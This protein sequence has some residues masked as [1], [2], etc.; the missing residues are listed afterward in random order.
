[1]RKKLTLTIDEKLIPKI[2]VI[3]SYK[4][5]SLSQLVEAGMTTLLEEQEEGFASRWRGKFKVS[6]TKQKSNLRYDYLAKKYL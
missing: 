6:K 5:V 3:A 4:G 1:M 2:K